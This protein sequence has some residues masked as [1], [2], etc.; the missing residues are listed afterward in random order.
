[1]TQ[2]SFD[3]FPGPSQQPLAVDFIENRET[4]LRDPAGEL[5]CVFDVKRQ[6][7]VAKTVLLPHA[8]DAMSLTDVELEESNMHLIKTAET[9]G[10]AINMLKSK[11]PQNP[12]IKNFSLGACDNWEEVMRTM[13]LAAKQYE[14]RDTKSGKFRSAFRKFGDHSASIKAFVGLLPDGNYKTLCGGLTLILTVMIARFIQNHTT[15]R[16]I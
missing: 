1:M 11:E 2:R 7:F 14:S 12:V 13:D 10:N 16:Y 5:P 4:D 15:D 3:S 8:H 9:F 6:K